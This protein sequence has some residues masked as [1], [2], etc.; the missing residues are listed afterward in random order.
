MEAKR[1]LPDGDIWHHDRLIKRSAAVRLMAERF[2]MPGGRAV[3]LA[4][5]AKRIEARLRN[6][7]Q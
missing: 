5:V 4:K 3:R 2:E 7:R 1:R 6:L